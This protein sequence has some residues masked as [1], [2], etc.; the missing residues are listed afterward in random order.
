MSGSSRLKLDSCQQTRIR[1]GPELDLDLGSQISCLP[2]LT[3][4]QRVASRVL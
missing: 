1:A 3:E 4:R 2:L